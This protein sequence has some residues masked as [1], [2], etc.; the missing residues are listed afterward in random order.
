MRKHDINR[1]RMYYT[2]LDIINNNKAAWDANAGF[3][4]V[5]ADYSALLKQIEE[6]RKGAGI[7]T[8]G[9]TDD[10]D[11]L[12]A[13]IIN[14][15]MEVSGPFGTM[16]KRAGNNELYGKASFTDSY[17]EHLPEDE[18]AQKAV[19]F[20]QLALDNADGLAKY[21]ITTDELNLLKTEAT[22]LRTKINEPREVTS[23]RKAANKQLKTTFTQASDLLTQQLD[24]LMDNYRRKATPFWDAYFNARKIV[25]Y[26][27]RYE[28]KPAETV[29]Q[30]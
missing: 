7:A 14:L 28:K 11:E 15:M 4:E 10:K 23:V 8:N 16:A 26:G 20:A 19:D 18:L 27:T 12:I 21:N 29:K 22:T 1:S 3:A 2:V 6:I 9:I 30:S 24:G 13:D 5:V 25:N 17:L